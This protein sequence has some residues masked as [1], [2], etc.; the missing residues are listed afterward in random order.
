MV[1]IFA[2]TM[3]GDEYGRRIIENMCKRGFIH[4]IV[5]VH[6]FAEVP[7]IEALLDDVD[8]LEGYLPPRIPECDLVLSLG[9]PSELQSL[10]PSIAKKAGAKAAIIAVDDP[11]WVPPGLRSQ[12]S[13]EMEEAG[14]A[15]VFPKPLCGL[16]KVGNPY[17]DEF[18]EQFGRAVLKIRVEDGVIRRV[19]V[20]R[21][22]PCGST[23]YI[24]EKL[25]GVPVEP[26]E[27]LWEELAKAHHVYP[28]LASM[29]NDPEIGDTILH[30]SQ[31][32]IREAVERAI[33]GE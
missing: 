24:A 7:P 10:V 16:D 12:M 18:A 17:I 33:A 31:Y 13:E 15:C 1:R 11:N 26:R 14:I 23:W 20:V 4:W 3:K 9:L 6:G 29:Q 28:C 19:D 30:K 27:A 25:V 8:A 21:G 2:L 32:I 22:S 5:G